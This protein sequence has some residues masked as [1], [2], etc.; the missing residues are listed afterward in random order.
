MNPPS[1]ISE[2]AV[3]HAPCV[4]VQQSAIPVTTAAVS[5]TRRAIEERVR[6]ATTAPTRRP[7]TAADNPPTDTPEATSLTKRERRHGA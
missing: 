2:E 4:R 3:L 5:M 1:R 7:G 6:N